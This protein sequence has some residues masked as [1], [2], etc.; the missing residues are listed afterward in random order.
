[1]WPGDNPHGKAES[2]FQYRSSVN[3]WCGL[4]RHV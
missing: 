3:V 2:S 1:L 4:I